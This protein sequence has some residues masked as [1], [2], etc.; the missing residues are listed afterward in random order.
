[1]RECRQVFL[2]DV[3]MMREMPR[4]DRGLAGY[5]SGFPCARLSAKTAVLDRER[6]RLE[7]ATIEVLRTGHHAIAIRANE[8]GVPLGRGNPQNVRFM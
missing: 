8:I 7:R 2:G 3:A 4:I 1:M 6:Y 5:H